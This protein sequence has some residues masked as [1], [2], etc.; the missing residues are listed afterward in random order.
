MEFTDQEKKIIK[1]AFV[2]EALTD[3]FLNLVDFRLDQHKGKLE[4][5]KENIELQRANG[6]VMALN[7]FKNDIRELHKTAVSE[8]PF[9]LDQA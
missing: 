8:R 4:V 5:P 6:S 7:E 9:P 2:S 3:L 1:E